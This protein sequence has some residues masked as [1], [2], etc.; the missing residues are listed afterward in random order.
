MIISVFPKKHS[1]ILSRRLKMKLCVR[2]QQCVKQSLREKKLVWHA[3]SFTLHISSEPGRVFGNAHQFHPCSDYLSSRSGRA[4]VKFWLDT[5]GA[6]LFTQQILSVA[7]PFFWYAYH[8][9]PSRAKN[10]LSCKLVFNLPIICIKFILSATGCKRRRLQ[11]VL[12][13]YC[14][15]KCEIITIQYVDKFCSGS[16]KRS[17]KHFRAVSPNENTDFAGM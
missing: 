5:D 15:V 17:S 8:F 3:Q 4:R 9:Y 14:G 11:I 10:F 1:K 16:F 12:V 13:R 6:K 7:S 2:I